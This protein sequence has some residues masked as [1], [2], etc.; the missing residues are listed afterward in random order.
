MANDSAAPLA[1]ALAQRIDLQE[2]LRDTLSDMRHKSAGELAAGPLRGTLSRLDMQPGETDLFALQAD[3]L[4]PGQAADPELD[5]ELRQLMLHDLRS[6][7][8]SVFA[9]I[10]PILEPDAAAQGPDPEALRDD[11]RDRVAQTQRQISRLL[12]IVNGETRNWLEPVG[13]DLS[14]ILSEI[15]TQIAP[16]AKQRGKSLVFH[17]SSVTNLVLGPAVLLREL[18]QNTIDNALKYG[19]GTVDVRLDQRLVSPGE[20]AITLD[21]WQ[22]GPGVTQEFFERLCGGGE[23]RQRHAQLPWAANHAARHDMARG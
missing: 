7:L 9:T 23:A 13:T 15:V 18:A 22:D 3:S 21:V 16:L 17:A 20:W 8:Q 4:A 12:S 10:E 11:I 19:S 2:T 1:N 6:L 5:A 14:D